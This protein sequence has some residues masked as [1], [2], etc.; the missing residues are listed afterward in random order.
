M[1]VGRQVSQGLGIVNRVGPLIRA[2][3]EFALAR[4]FAFR[5]S[6]SG[7]SLPSRTRDTLGR[8]RVG[9]LG[10]YSVR[11]SF[12]KGRELWIRDKRGLTKRE[13][14]KSLNASAAA[15]M[16]DGLPRSAMA[17]PSAAA[18]SGNRV[19]MIPPCPAGK[20]L[21]R[22]RLKK[23][24]CPAVPAKRPSREAPIA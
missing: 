8:V 9:E 21:P 4:R 13:V 17:W 20:G 10:L 18:K 22:A 11:P 7:K 12:K 3:I 15:S 2:A 19:T 14:A 24:A 5:V 6:R 1:K 16:V 23:L